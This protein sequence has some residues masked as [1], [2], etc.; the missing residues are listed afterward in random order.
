MRGSYSDGRTIIHCSSCLSKLRVPVDKG[1]ITVTCPAC[2]KE[3]LYNPNNVL[4]TLKQIGLS[5]VA[6]LPKG[7]RNRTIIIAA[8]ALII[9]ALVYLYFALQGSKTPKVPELAPGPGIT[10]LK[11]FL[12]HM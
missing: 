6:L 7:R 3:F 8:A 9:I 1:K 10:V 11:T 2:R 4:H 5:A 12:Y